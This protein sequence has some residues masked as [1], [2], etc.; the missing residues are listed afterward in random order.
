MNFFNFF[1][2]LDM[3]G[4]GANFHI[5]GKKKYKTYVGSIV[6]CIVIGLIIAI[7][8]VFSKDV[9]LRKELM[10]TFS[11][12]YF[13]DKQNISSSTFIFALGIQ[14]PNYTN[15]IDE[16][17]YVLNV[18]LQETIRNEDGNP[19]IK[20]TNLK[21][22][23]CNLLNI[24]IIPEYFNG[25]GMQNLY[26]LNEPNITLQGEFGGT[27]WKYLIFR[28][29]K[30]INSTLNN[31]SCKS[32]EIINEK[33]LGGYFG[34]FIT[35]CYVDN[36]N[37]YK[38]V[39]KYGKNFF[40]AFSTK[41]YQDLWVY[42]KKIQVITDYGYFFE[43]K[44]IIEDIGLD[45]LENTIDYKESVNFLSVK[46][47]MSTKMEIYQRNSKKVTEA[48]GNI[49]GFMK[50]IL[51]VSKV[52]VSYFNTLL[53]QKYLIQFFKFD[54]KY[55]SI[56]LCPKPKFSTLYP[57]K[58]LNSNNNNDKSNISNNDMNN[59]NNYNNNKNFNINNNNN[60]TISKNNNN[61][62]NYNNTNTFSNMNNINNINNNS[63][64]KFRNNTEFWTL[65]PKVKLLTKNVSFHDKKKISDKQLNYISDRKKFFFLSRVHKSKRKEDRLWC[66]IYCKKKGFQKARE[67][68]RKYKSI[69]FL[70]DIIYY[71]KSLFKIQLLEYNLFDLKKRKTII[72]TDCFD[73][74]YFN[75]EKNCYDVKYKKSKKILFNLD[76]KKPKQSTISPFSNYTNDK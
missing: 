45:K 36:T 69:T 18:S 35:D 19:N 32:N 16:S 57:L 58:H 73:Y 75:E 27:Y 59:N 43:D 68:Y 70:T 31:N 6:S 76:S 56:G 65:F 11:N 4:K 66:K 72:E 42:L 14:D 54:D 53:L 8:I 74:F 52:C 13:S 71:Y 10:S 38:P 48:I 23:K 21:I 34:G 67:I 39:I 60:N 2:K 64:F 5:N 40:T 17:I 62:N 46:V 37:F 9:V 33:L 1:L 30:C 20:T 22:E 7:I 26:C 25:V 50:I 44:R 29:S 24:T 12:N 3:F 47:R 63:E 51:V 55:D 28:F 61:N 41:Q 15:Y 49:G